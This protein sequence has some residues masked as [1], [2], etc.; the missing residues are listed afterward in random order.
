MPTSVQEQIVAIVKT[1]LESI[2]IAN[3]YSFDVASVDRVNRLGED[4]TPRHLSLVVVAPD[5]ERNTEH[6]RPGNP[7]VTAYRLPIA[8][9]AFIRLSDK[10]AAI[11]DTTVNDVAA[12][13]KK[14]ITS[15]A[16]W[17]TFGGNSYLADWGTFEKFES[18]DHMGFTLQIIPLYR[19]SEL[20][21]F[22]ALP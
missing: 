12:N 9:H 6:D 7:P 10:T 20:D 4:F 16:D 21:P 18:T 1:R 15:A 2:T 19:V 5:E 14:A 8:I 3:G 11:E 13:V 22:T 17:Y